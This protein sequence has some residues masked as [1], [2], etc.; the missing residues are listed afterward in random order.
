M[1]ADPMH[2]ITDRVGKEV[3]KTSN[4]PGHENKKKPF[5]PHFYTIPVGTIT[6]IWYIFLY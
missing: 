2:E 3:Q 4:I 5:F 6:V 1:E